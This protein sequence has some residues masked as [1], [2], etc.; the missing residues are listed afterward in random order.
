MR[1]LQAN[2]RAVLAA[3]L[4]TI[5]LP[6]RLLAK[7]PTLPFSTPQANL[8]AYVKLVGSIASA[9]KYTHYQGTLYAVIAGKIPK[10]LLRFE[11]LGKA[12][13]TPQE[14][15]SYLRKSHDIGFFGD[16]ETREPIYEYPNPLNGRNTVPLHYRNGR[17]ETLYTAQGPRLPWRGTDQ[18]DERGPFAPDWTVSGD[19]VWVNDEVSGE[20]DS[21]LDPEDWPLAS[22][23]KKIQ[24]RSTV[25]SKGRL[26]QLQDPD[27]M[28]GDCTIV[29]TG[30]FPWLP[31][32]Q[33]GQQ[34]GFLLWRSIGRKIDASDEA[35]TRILDYIAKHQP[36]YLTVEDP[37]MDRKNSWIDYAKERKPV[38]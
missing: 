28:S 35:S 37:W 30:L 34:P 12:R 7:A 31:W 5:V 4:A 3:G 22:S 23:G 17:G 20:R 1:V 21:W 38:R 10:P 8:E 29:W 26:S 27:I 14:D 19:G 16:L 36:N 33:M 6:G 13:W 32:M 15:G 25:T 18:E 11:A 9:I 24:I 2:R